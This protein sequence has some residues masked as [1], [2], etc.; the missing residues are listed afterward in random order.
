MSSSGFSKLDPRFG[1]KIQ[2]TMA[3]EV[4]MILSERVGYV[5]IGVYQG[6]IFTRFA[7]VKTD[8]LA[9]IGKY[10]HLKDEDRKVAQKIAEEIWPDG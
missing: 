6:D 3:G 8:H 7:R 9:E 2:S 5:D 1:A 4:Q 10:L